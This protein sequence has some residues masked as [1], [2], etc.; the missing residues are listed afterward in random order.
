MK[1]IMPF[2]GLLCLVLTGCQTI[3]Q[4]TVR[5]YTAANGQHVM[6]GQAEPDD[7]YQCTKVVQEKEAWGLTGNMDQAA[8]M[9]RMREV[10]LENMP[11]K[12]A[13]YG[14]LIVPSN[15]SIMG[16]NINAFDDAEIAYYRC[17]KLPPNK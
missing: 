17:D 6:I 16:F 11:E 14:Y 8:A 2:A 4:L 7:D 12:N 5:D 15:T 13:N 9:E 10:A 1:T 3:G